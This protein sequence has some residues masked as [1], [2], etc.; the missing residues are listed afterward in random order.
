MPPLPDYCLRCGFANFCPGQPQTAILCLPS[1]WDYRR[2][3]QLWAT[4][5]KQFW[6]KEV[7]AEIC[8]GQTMLINQ[9]SE[10]FLEERMSQSCRSGCGGSLN[11]LE[12][13][14]S[15]V[16]WGWGREVCLASQPSREPPSLQSPAVL[17]F[18]SFP[19]LFR[20]RVVLGA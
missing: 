15:M 16:R 17:F 11:F 14:G 6:C 7:N 10:G 13:W 8:T 1:N 20:C 3:P 2:E 5:N 18:L 9:V 4:I 12:K 19:S